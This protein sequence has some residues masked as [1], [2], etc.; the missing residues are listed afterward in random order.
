M[1]PYLDSVRYV[2]Y[3][4]FYNTYN[5]DTLEQKKSFYWATS[6]LACVAWRF[7][8]FERERTN[9]PRLLATL[10][11]LVAASPRSWRLQITFKK[12][13]SYAGYISLAHT[14]VAYTHGQ[15]VDDELTNQSARFALSGLHKAN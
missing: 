12:P 10:A 1:H 14:S 6:H 7:K 15:I 9:S 3:H 13:P 2:I 4:L 11:V 8:Q 5:I